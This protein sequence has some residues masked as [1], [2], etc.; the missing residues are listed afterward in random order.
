M[1][2]VCRYFNDHEDNLLIKY[3]ELLQAPNIPNRDEVPIIELNDSDENSIVLLGRINYIGDSSWEETKGTSIS[4]ETR[5]NYTKLSG[6][7]CND[8]ISTECIIPGKGYKEV[9][10]EIKKNSIVAINGAFKP[11]KGRYIFFDDQ[12]IS[13]IVNDY[14]VIGDDIVLDSE[15][16]DEGFFVDR[17]ETDRNRYLNKVVLTGVISNIGFKVTRGYPHMTLHLRTRIVD[18][19]EE[20]L[21]IPVEIWEKHL[22]DCFKDLNIGMSI[23]VEGYFKHPIVNRYYYSYEPI[24]AAVFAFK[25]KVLNSDYQPST[26]SRQSR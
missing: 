26:S 19:K 25:Y 13:V 22:K 18:D 10:K 3:W 12:E 7:V 23:W 17:R 6:I 11:E 2:F 21:E 4:I 5:I 9:E 14:V 8:Y 15:N 16:G 1:N 20:F 24:D